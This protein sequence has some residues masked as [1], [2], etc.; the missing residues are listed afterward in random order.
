MTFDLRKARKAVVAAVGTAITSGV[1][2]L[3]V[4]LGWAPEATAGI[5]AALIA[6]VTKLVHRIPNDV[7]L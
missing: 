3:T 7:T 1:T 6:T 5:T 2:Y 4:K